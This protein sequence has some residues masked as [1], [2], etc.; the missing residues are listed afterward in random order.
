MR[1]NHIIIGCKNVAQSA[2]FY[3]S[4][5]GFHVS[6]SF[7]DTGTGREGTVM[8]LDA[9]GADL[10]L[11]LVPFEDVRLPSPQHVAFEVANERMFQSLLS[12]ASGKGLQIRPEPSLKCE[13]SG[14]GTLA[15]HNKNYRLFYVLDP[16][17]VN[18]EVMLRE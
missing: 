14:I 11:L 3:E 2:A 13:K 12:A 5:F 10:D 15:I 1:V 6:Q 16:S 17:G 18:V 8:H 9:N 7:I 4:L